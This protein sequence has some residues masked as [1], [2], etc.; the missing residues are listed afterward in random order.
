MYPPHPGSI[1]HMTK[2]QDAL[3]FLYYNRNDGLRI[4]DLHQGI[5]WGTD[6]GIY[7]YSRYR[8]MYKNSC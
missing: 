6:T 4:T 3:A 2:T 7:Q 1:Y 8:K 5:V